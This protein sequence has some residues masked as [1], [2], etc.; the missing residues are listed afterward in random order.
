MTDAGAGTA[1]VGGDDVVAYLTE[2]DTSGLDYQ[3]M[4]RLCLDDPQ[5]H[6]IAFKTACES[7]DYG[8][9]LQDK[10][11]SVKVNGSRDVSRCSGCYGLGWTEKLKRYQM[12]YAKPGEGVTLSGNGVAPVRGGDGEKAQNHEWKDYF[13]CYVKVG[14]TTSTQTTTVTTMVTTSVTST[15]PLSFVVDLLW[16]GYTCSPAAPWLGQ[17]DTAEECAKLCQKSPK[18]YSMS[19]IVWVKNGDKNCKCAADDCTPSEW[20]WGAVYSFELSTGTTTTSIPSNGWLLVQS[21]GACR[22][23]AP[24]DN[25]AAYYVVIS[26]TSF[27]ECQTQMQSKSTA[28]RGVKWAAADR[29]CEIWTRPNG[30]EAVAN[31]SGFE[32]YRRV[33]HPVFSTV[34]AV[35]GPGTARRGENTSDISA[36]HYSKVSAHSIENCQSQCENDA[37][38]QG[39][40]F[41]SVAQLE[42]RSGQYGYVFFIR[43]MNQ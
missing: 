20:Q 8:S 6:A 37:M 1:C 23:A 13:R 31:V 21:D 14:T 12:R 9:L 10:K 25:S 35:G 27:E 41:N 34:G 26:A 17:T 4:A 7:I 24:S 40:N 38:C 43:A 18:P 29:R 36:S 39:I 22:G 5:C 42:H 32:C 3:Q 11:V 28:M 19:R 30:I 15:T 16:E 2:S 33:Q